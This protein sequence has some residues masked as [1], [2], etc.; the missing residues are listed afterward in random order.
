M[1]LFSAEWGAEVA[2]QPDWRDGLEG[3]TERIVFSDASPL[4]VVAGPGTGKTYAIVRRVAR[5]LHAGIPAR[6]IREYVHP[7]RGN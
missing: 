6:N 7:Y 1:S 4:K 2:N 3:P 5:L